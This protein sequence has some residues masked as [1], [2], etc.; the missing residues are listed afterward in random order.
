MGVQGVGGTA[1]LGQTEAMLTALALLA[2]QASTVTPEQADARCLTA[3]GALASSDKE[4]AQ[5]AAQLAALYFY[6]K[7]LGRNPGIALQSVLT[8]AATAVAPDPKPVLARCGE[9]LKQSGLA[10]QTVGAAIR[11]G[12]AAAPKK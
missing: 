3:M 1:A 11:D 5:R 2:A 4:E 12:A 8:E 7:L 9:E 10:L 6:G